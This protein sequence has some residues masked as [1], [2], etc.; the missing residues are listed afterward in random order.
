MFDLAETRIGRKKNQD[1]LLNVLSTELGE[2]AGVG[3]PEI[4]F[5]TS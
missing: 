3:A 1:R 2:G 4:V 5:L